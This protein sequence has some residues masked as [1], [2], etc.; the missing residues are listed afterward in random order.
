MTTNTPAPEPVPAPVKKV[1]APVPYDN[2]RVVIRP[3]PKVV[4]LYP[5]FLGACL[6]FL[7]A[8]L[9]VQQRTLGNSFTFLLCLNLLVFSF[10]FS[11]I[12]SITIVIAIIAI[13]LGM[14]WLDTKWNVTG[15]LGRLVSGIDI[16]L[17]TSFYGF[18]SA[19]LGFLLLLVFVNSRFHYYEVNAREILHHHGYLGDITRWSTDGL[20]MNKEIYDMAEYLLLRSGRLI[21]LPTNAKKAI[22]IDN[23]IHVNRIELRVNDLLSHIAVRLDQRP[24]PG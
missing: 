24:G 13:V 19:F 3:W 2:E 10:D 21:F 6:C 16:Q 9:D 8:M 1:E 7:L 23:V 20:E 15:F 12:K 14:L 4:F 17:N 11:R 22:V 18:F 5:T